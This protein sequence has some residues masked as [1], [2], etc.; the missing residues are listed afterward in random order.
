G[1]GGGGA[2]FA[3]PAV[4]PEAMI[5]GLLAGVLGGGL[6]VLVWWLFFSRAPWSERVGALAL[7]AVGMFATSRLVHESIATGAMGMLL[8]FLAIPV[9]CLALVG[10]AA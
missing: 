2:G 4:V 5:Y 6:A 8:P 3:L 1:G 10:W 7:M 9:L